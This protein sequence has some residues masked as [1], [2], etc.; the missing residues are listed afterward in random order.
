M[1]WLKTHQHMQIAHV[2]IKCEDENKDSLYNKL[3]EIKEVK[4][5]EYTF[6]PYDAIIRLETE[7]KKSIKQIILDKIRNVG[8][9]QSTLT[10]ITT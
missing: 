9:I 3:K 10:L 2:L 7:T 8:G 4:H 5:I 6:G 1:L